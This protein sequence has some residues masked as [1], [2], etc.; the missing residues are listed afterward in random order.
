MLRF[1][2]VR[3]CEPGVEIE[4][5][6][7][8]RLRLSSSAYFW[9]RVTSLCGLPSASSCAKSVAVACTH[10][11][12]SS[13]PSRPSRSR[14]RVSVVTHTGISC[15]SPECGAALSLWRAR[16]QLSCV[17]HGAALSLWPAHRATLRSGRRA[18]G[19]LLHSPVLV[20]V[21]PSCFYKQLDM[22]PRS[23]RP[24]ANKQKNLENLRAASPEGTLA[25]ASRVAT[26]EATVST[27]KQLCWWL[28]GSQAFDP[29]Q[30]SSLE[31]RTAPLPATLD[32]APRIKL[33]QPHCQSARQRQ[34][35]SAAPPGKLRGHPR[36]LPRTRTR[37]QTAGSRRGL[38]LW[39]AASGLHLLTPPAAAELAHRGGNSS[40]QA[41]RSG[42]VARGAPPAHKARGGQ[43]P[44]LLAV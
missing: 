14:C 13:S 9:T 2:A 10:G 31:R 15:V 25:V 39:P 19:R 29:A 43:R 8:L 34:A 35:P 1:A 7:A 24:H 37:R 11:V 42:R 26:V 20:E 28:P 44:G 36:S 3:F 5:V 21:L 33:C 38:W 27:S 22:L 16:T 12:R 23:R 18:G 6:P 40:G 30:A 32:S 41:A 4:L 17:S